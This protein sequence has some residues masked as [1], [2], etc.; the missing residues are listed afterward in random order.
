MGRELSR[1]PKEIRDRL[2]RGTNPERDKA[3]LVELGYKPVSEWDMEELA[4]ARP[5]DR[6]GSFSTGSAPRWLTADIQAEALKRLKESAFSE[7]MALFPL[8][9]KTILGVLSSTEVDDN[10]RPV[11]DAKTKLQAATWV[12]EH[13]IGKAMQ[14][15]SIEVN[16]EDFTK[17]AIASAII[18]DDGLPEEHWVVEGELADGEDPDTDRPWLEPDEL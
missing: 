2:R 13:A 3:M 17:R 12:S 9:A 1:N 4:R 15:T 7:I 6:N 11:V 5:R 10:G 16:A 8:A 18:L 14:R